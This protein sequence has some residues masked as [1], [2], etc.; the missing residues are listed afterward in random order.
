MVAWWL[1]QPHS[2]PSISELFLETRTTTTWEVPS[3]GFPKNCKPAKLNN[4]KTSLIHQLSPTPIEV[5]VS[6]PHFGQSI[7]HTPPNPAPTH[8]TS[9]LTSKPPVEKSNFICPMVLFPNVKPT[10]T[11]MPSRISWHSTPCSTP[12]SFLRYKHQDTKQR[13]SRYKQRIYWHMWQWYMFLEWIF[14]KTYA[15]R[16]IF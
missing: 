2:K 5:I 8:S 3:F 11:L 1:K 16:C 7:L 4:Y 14:P 9:P 6:D 10:Y 13:G 15:T 12:L